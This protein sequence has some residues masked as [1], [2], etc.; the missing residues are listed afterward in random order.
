MPFDRAWLE[1]QGFKG[2]VTVQ[3]FKTELL[4]NRQHRTLFNHIP[5]T[6]GVYVVFR[7]ESE[8]PEY[9]DSNVGGHFHGIDPTVLVETLISNWVVG[10]QVIYIGKADNLRRR[11]RHLIRFADGQPAAH[12]GGRTLWQ[13]CGC[14]RF[15]IAYKALQGRA[16]ITPRDLEQQYIIE[17]EAQ[18]RSL[19]FANRQ[20]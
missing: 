2:F 10:A 3:S 5:Q 15:L 14:N 20:H 9:L 1:H 16:D 12:R 7:T 19:P 4:L 11:I 6:G 17:F 8:E 18:Y 13:V